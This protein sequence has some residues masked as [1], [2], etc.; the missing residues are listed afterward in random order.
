MLQTPKGI[1]NIA[2]VTELRSS[3]SE[4]VDTANKSGEGLLIV[5]N[6]TPYAVL[7]S[8]DRYNEM[9]NGSR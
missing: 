5:K 9:L 8:F 6:N 4:V 7:V 3:T 1:S 2:T